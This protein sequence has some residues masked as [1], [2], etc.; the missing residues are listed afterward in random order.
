MVPHSTPTGNLLVD[1]SSSF[2]FDGYFSGGNKLLSSGYFYYY[3]EHMYMTRT[4]GIIQIDGTLVFEGNTSSNQAQ[5]RA[6]F[7][8]SGFWSENTGELCMVGSDQ[9]E[10]NRLVCTM[11]SVC[12]TRSQSTSFV[13]S[14]V[15]RLNYP[16]NSNISTSLVKGTVES[17]DPVD[18]QNY[19]DMISVL[20][21]AQMNYS[22]AMISEVRDSC[23]SWGVPENALGIDGSDPCSYLPSLLFGRFMLDIIPGFSPRFMNF[24]R[25]Q[26]SENGK[27][28]MHISFFNSSGYEH[29]KMHI[30]D[31]SLVGEGFWDGEKKK[32]CL[33]ACPI[34]DVQDSGTNGYVGDCTIG[35][36]FFFPSVFSLRNHSATLG[37]TWSN[38]GKNAPG[39][40]PMISFRSL[41]IGIDILSGWRYE[42]TEFD[43]VAESFCLNEKALSFGN[44]RHPEGDSMNDMRFGIT[45]VDTKGNK[46][47]G[48]TSP[49]I[50]GETNVYSISDRFSDTAEVSLPTSENR[51]QR[52]WNIG[53]RIRYSYDMKQWKEISAEGIYNAETGKLCM[54]GCQYVSTLLDCKI[55]VNIQLTP[56]NP[57]DGEYVTGKIT[58]T[59]KKYDPLYFEPLRV[60]SSKLYNEQETESV[61]D[62]EIAMVLISLPLSCSFILLQIFHIKEHQEMLQSISI[63]ML[64]ILAVG[65]MIPLVPNFMAVFSTSL[66]E[67]RI[68][69]SDITVRIMTMLAFLLQFHLLQSAWTS[70]GVSIAERKALKLC[71]PF[72]F[73][74]AIIAWFVHWRSYESQMKISLWGLILDGFL[75]PQIIFNMI[76]NS[77][78]K[79]LHPLFYVGITGV[80]ALPHLYDAYRDRQCFPPFSSSEMNA[81]PDGELYSFAW[82]VIIPVQGFLFALLVYLQQ[83]FGGRCLLPK[84]TRTVGG[85]EM[86]HVASA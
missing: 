38:K 37:K 16:K 46:M 10:H 25:I 60:S 17:L 65:Y 42:Y 71:L 74:G 66:N 27:I 12:R 35:F 26:C 54:V 1:S 80:R 62:V 3:T 67:G 5:K 58:S 13:H 7:S 52:L 9:V 39:Y 8:L 82:D 61:M 4:P 33:L 20:A 19:F 30:P 28:H 15:F 51:N 2:Q 48:F 44:K 40:F 47:W 56:I 83:Q 23:S 31:R 81:S 84:M 70:K 21:Y 34:L 77:R 53:Y 76:S 59:R 22:Y 29:D 73:T 49:L 64:A 57:E 11:G 78:G 45:V 75:F 24:N 50:F 14:V 79:A 36:S 32:L 55:L 72:Y 18:S 68:S 41:E 43:T 86:V 63:M 6:S 85:Y 69:L